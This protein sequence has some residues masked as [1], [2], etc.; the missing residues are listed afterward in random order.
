MIASKN[1]RILSTWRDY[2]TSIDYGRFVQS[3]TIH[4]S[5]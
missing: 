5:R 4:H 1:T 3:E 2:Y